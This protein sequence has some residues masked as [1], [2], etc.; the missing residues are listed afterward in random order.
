MIY[1]IKSVMAIEFE[2]VARDERLQELG[3]AHLLLGSNRLHKEFFGLLEDLAVHEEH[4]RQGIGRQLI[5]EVIR[6][7]NVYDCYKL[8]ATSRHGREYVHAIYLEKGF[9]DHGKE[10]RMDLKPP[11]P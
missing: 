11:T 3:Y 1:T 6:L 9:K 5:D 2:I 7:A 4:Q 10:F 8:I